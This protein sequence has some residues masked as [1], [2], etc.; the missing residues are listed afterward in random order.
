MPAFRDTTE[1]Q[2]IK[3]AASG[4]TDL[5]RRLDTRFEQRATI[6]PEHWA[7]FCKPGHADVVCPQC[8]EDLGLPQYLVDHLNAYPAGLKEFTRISIQDAVERG[9]KLEFRW[10]LSD[11]DAVDRKRDDDKMRITFLA[12][13]EKVLA[14]VR[15]CVAV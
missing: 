1:I 13:R 12:D 5:T 10:K 11:H 9:L 4:E 3:E 14:E 7:E 15:G 8:I 2:L 6:S